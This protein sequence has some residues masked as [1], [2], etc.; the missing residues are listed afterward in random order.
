MHLD[1]EPFA[2]AALFIRAVAVLGYYP[3][4]A[5][6]L[7]DAEGGKAVRREPVRYEELLRR[8][9]Y[10]RFELL[11]ALGKWCGPKI[12]AVAIETIEHREA[13]G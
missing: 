2:G 10:G 9:S 12:R 8:C 13:Q 5:L 3:L 7:G 6:A 4:Q 11:P 1:L